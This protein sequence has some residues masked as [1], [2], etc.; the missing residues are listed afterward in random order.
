[1]GK[2]HSLIEGGSAR[3]SE[4]SC[5]QLYDNIMHIKISPIL[6]HT[7]IPSTVP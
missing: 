4:E 2:V 6:H 3:C 1:M 5:A 7:S